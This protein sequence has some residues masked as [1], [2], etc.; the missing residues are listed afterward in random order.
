MG[1]LSAIV[2]VA[3]GMAASLASADDLRPSWECLPADTAVMVRVPGARAFWET[4]QKQTKFGSVALRPERLESLWRIM[5]DTAKADGDDSLE[6]L[7]ESLRKDG[8]ELTDLAK[9]FDGEIGMGV[10]V[11]SL[12]GQP[13]RPMLLAWVEPGEEVAQKLLAS[14][15]RQVE[16]AD[17][18]E[19]RTTRVDLELAGHTVTT[20]AVPV[21][22]L[23]IED[24]E[25]DTDDEGLDEEAIQSQLEAHLER[26]KDA[27][28]KK[29]GER[30]V[31]VTVMGG[32]LLIGGT[33]VTIDD[34]K[35]GDDAEALRRVFGMFL[36]AHST[37]GEP[38][39]AAVLREP[40]IAAATV[41]GTPLFEGLVAPKVLMTAAAKDIA[42][43][44]S[45]LAEV[46]LDDVGGIVQRVSFDNGQWRSVL[47]I[48]MPAPR[49]GLFEML[50]QPC[51]A[52]EVPAFV[53]RE[54]SDFTQL[55]LDLGAA[56]K[57]VRQLLLEQAD[58]EQ[59]A[60]MFSVADVQSQAWL[61]LDV[62]AVL[63]GL[64]SRHWILTFPPNVAEAMARV[65]A[66]EDDDDAEMQLAD[67]MAVV[68]QVADDAPY[69]KLVGRLA[70]LAGGE[71]DEEQGFE[72]VRIPGAAGFYVGRGHLVIGIGEGTIEKTL[73]AIRTPPQGEISL[74]ESD[75]PRR[76]AELLPARPARMYGVSDS[77]RSGGTLG[78]LRDMAA[79]L[80]PDD[81]DDDFRSAFA[82][83]KELLPTA[84]EMEG[85]FGI[86]AVLLRMTDDGLLLESAWEMPAP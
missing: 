63:S 53:T 56:Y 42:D 23:D 13:A 36:E 45:K 74:R 20:F 64:G 14:M 19:P 51:D 86:G 73:A 34:A 52:S 81:V 38:A 70:Q 11:H 40:G 55:S 1:R 76:A 2:W 48:T 59:V 32:R 68:W 22:E 49:H 77:T 6:K 18:K 3:V 69:R 85:M 25:I 37:S 27:P 84:R 5:T 33:I 67:R 12:P 62:A 9:L 16:E 82:A 54:T 72:G 21:T 8:L 65:R 7:E 10:V 4:I 17:D 31:L 83:L 39:L 26:L 15:Q 66:A 44:R 78:T 58:G 30:Q 61:G 57:S 43:L 35:G 75:V 46:G 60:N 50:D 28:L 47:A 71:L 41:P 29:T 79:T 80:E 24:F